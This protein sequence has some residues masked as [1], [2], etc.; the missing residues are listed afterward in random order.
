MSELERAQVE[1]KVRTVIGQTF[2]LS[3][4]E[5]AG[6]LRMG[7][8]T[9]WDSMGHMQLIVGL[10]EACNWS[11]PGHQIADLVDVPTIVDAICNPSN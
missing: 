11:C 5:A 3:P 6:E 8:P 10:E 7:N 2:G 4:A 1:A 9:T